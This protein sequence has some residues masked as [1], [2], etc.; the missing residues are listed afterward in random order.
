MKKLVRDEAAKLLKNVDD[1]GAAVTASGKSL[2]FTVGGKEWKYP[3][4]L[5]EIDPDN[6]NAEYLAW[7]Q[8]HL[9]YGKLVVLAKSRFE[10]WKSHMD[11]KL[12]TLDR[13]VRA[14]FQKKGI[15]PTEKMVD[16]RIKSL[17]DYRMWM[18]E[19]IKRREDYELAQL[20]RDALEKKKDL[21]LQGYTR[22]KVAEMQAGLRQADLESA[23]FDQKKRR[24]DRGIGDDD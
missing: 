9:W 22:I 16:Q 4:N 13:A 2:I 12:S 20:A 11:I 18:E 3:S 7:G 21:L 17:P 19:L 15:K 23:S 6:L 8:H 24:R 14:L 1:R 10:A 5:S